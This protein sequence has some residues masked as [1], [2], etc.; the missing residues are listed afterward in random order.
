MNRVRFPSRTEEIDLATGELLS[1]LE[2]SSITVNTLNDQAIFVAPEVHQ[3]GITAVVLTMLHLAE[4]ANAETMMEVYSTFRSGAEGRQADTTYDM[5]WLGFELLKVDKYEHARA[6]FKQVIAENPQSPD[7]YAS[8]GEA[9]L[10]EGDRENAAA[11]FAN[12]INLGSTD[13]GLK[14][15]LQDLLAAP[16]AQ[17]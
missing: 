11:A 15:K 8:L 16:N 2:A 9:Y 12:A 14:R 4:L 10:Q 1:G 13:A 3:A 5:N 7:A 6:V 17:P